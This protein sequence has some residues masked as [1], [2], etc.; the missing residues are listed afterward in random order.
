MDLITT[1]MEHFEG[2]DSHLYGYIAAQQMML[3]IW[4]GAQPIIADF[5]NKYN[6]QLTNAHS[7]TGR[8][9]TALLSS[10]DD[11]VD[12]KNYD[13]IAMSCEIKDDAKW[14]AQSAPPAA[15]QLLVRVQAAWRGYSVR[16]INYNRIHATSTYTNMAEWPT[17][18]TVD[19]SLKTLTAKAGDTMDID[20]FV[21]T[22]PKEM[23][24]DTITQ[25]KNAQEAVSQ[26]KKLDTMAASASIGTAA[27]V[28]PATSSTAAR[29]GDVRITG[30]HAACAEFY[31]I[32]LYNVFIRQE[33]KNIW[34]GMCWSYDQTLHT[35]GDML[36]QNEK[37]K[38]MVESV[39]AEL[40][41]KVM[42][43][44]DVPAPRRNQGGGDHTNRAPVYT[45]ESLFS[46]PGGRG[47]NSGGDHTSRL[48]RPGAQAANEDLLRGGVEHDAAKD[49]LESYLREMGGDDTMFKDIAP[50]VVP[51]C[52]G[53]SP[54]RIDPLEF[55]KN[56]LAKSDKK[57]AK[58]AA[59][60]SSDGLPDAEAAINKKL[61]ELGVGAEDAPAP[62]APK[63]D[64]Q[65]CMD[66]LKPIF[67]TMKAHRFVSA[68]AAILQQLPQA[69]VQQYVQN[70]NSGKYIHCVR[71]LE[72]ATVGNINVLGDTTRLIS[73]KPLPIDNVF[74]LI[75]GYIGLHLKSGRAEEAI[76]LTNRAI[77]SA[78][79]RRDDG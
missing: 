1:Y 52:S 11:G 20:S 9:P 54:R 62:A 14:Q 35:F 27:L 22:L 18:Q 12:S 5:A 57:A 13:L 71:L 21:P 37:L 63:I 79:A 49:Y 7:A 74:Q 46:K 50:E 15:I 59:A 56:K 48:H 29:V 36:N 55:F 61:N 70:E 67:L 76:E 65:F 28:P 78:M 64:T 23:G 39:S 33:L 58:K 16:A 41:R 24:N 40:K 75:V 66:N 8:L 31:A 4:K 53:A 43:G 30:D 77:E 19:P 47:K 38:P 68:R 72:C 44:R 2:P 45:D 69:V 6:S 3:A 51:L 17:V 73:N 26:Q 42:Q 60:A 10:T 34:G 25:I 32:Y